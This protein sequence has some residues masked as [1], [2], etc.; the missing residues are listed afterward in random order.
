M[1]TKEQI[2]EFQRRLEATFSHNGVVG[3]RLLMGAMDQ[4]NAAGAAF[5]EK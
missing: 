2:I 5:V 4:E 1:A 3:G